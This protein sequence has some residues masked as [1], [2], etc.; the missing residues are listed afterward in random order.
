MMLQKINWPPD[1]IRIWL[2]RKAR[3]E[4]LITSPANIVGAIEYYRT[5]P[6]EFIEHWCYT[7]DPRNAGTER[8]TK[9]PFILF[10]RQREFVEFLHG[11][12]QEETHGLIEK[13]RDMGATWLAA[14]FSVWLFLFRKDATVGWGSRKAANV[15][16]IGDM[17]SIF[18]K[19]RWQLRCMPPIFIRWI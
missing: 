7:F 16:Q 15:D 4:Y 13:S 12:L 5:R 18:E 17:S 11:C 6:V 2:D 19:M 14:S 10:P 8:P 3:Y 1:Y 9:I